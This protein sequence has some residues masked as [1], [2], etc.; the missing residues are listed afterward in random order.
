MSLA[1]AVVRTARPRQWLKNGLV[2]AAPGAA[3]VL[4][5]GS[6]LG[7]SLVAFVAFC[8]A[9]SGTYFVNDALDAEA[10][11]HH[12]EKRNRPVAAGALGVA[13]AIAIGI[14]AMVA[15]VGLSLGA[16]RPK[17]ALVVAIYLAVT[18]C[19][20]VWLKH[21]P[22][23]DI[24][25][26][27]AGFVLRAIAGGVAVDVPLSVWFLI[28]AS[29]GSLLMVSGKRYAE[30]ATLGDERGE[31]R[32]T[33]EAYSPAYL[34]YVRSVSSSVAVTAYCL[35]A[36]EKAGITTCVTPP[37]TLVRSSHGA[38]FFQ[39]S[40]VPFALGILRYGLLLDSG[41]GG[42]PEDVVLGD[43]TLQVLGVVLAA[44]FAVGL[45]LN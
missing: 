3:G 12:P 32:V 14:G 1:T 6:A 8:F 7:R 40:V 37:C 11:R 4:S 18:C 35:W 27:A 9:A 30:S 24:G 13:P 16:G 41:K 31:H 2:F 20:T 34:R 10:D 5:H 36:F 38:L 29:S 28:V 25:A 17:L 44:M 21:Q 23:L 26:V 19:Y 15:A 42:A 45:Y 33:L 22:V 43:R 39:L